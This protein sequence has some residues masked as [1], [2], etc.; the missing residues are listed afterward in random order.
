MSFEKRQFTD[1][2]NIVGK[3]K[4]ES[5][6]L[7]YTTEAKDFIA[8]HPG[9]I[10]DVLEGI[11]SDQ[12]KY[13]RADGHEGEPG[14][15]WEKDGITIETI[16]TYEPHN[17]YKVTVDDK[18]FFLKIN[19]IDEE[20]FNEEEGYDGAVEMVSTRKAQELFKDD[21]DVIVPKI[22]LGYSGVK[23]SKTSKEMVKYFVSEWNDA[24]LVEFRLF[25]DEMNNILA[26]QPNDHV[27]AFLR[28]LEA[29]VE[30]VKSKLNENGFADVGDFNL[31]YDAK[32]KKIVIFDL[33][34]DH[35]AD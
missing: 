8:S 27:E 32:N 17:A 23:T 5:K 16:D 7:A 29:K 20:D 24:A 25:K 13:S 2:F 15:K 9:L 22:Y 28:K 19:I 14:T 4:K 11:R 21:P 18:S 1:G 3:D 31:S 30:Q 12:L 33:T 10:R 26:T 34:K 35:A 6:Q